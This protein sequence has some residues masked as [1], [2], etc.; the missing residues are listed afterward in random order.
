ML[1]DAS[2]EIPV[3]VSGKLR[4]RIV[5]PAGADAKT[6]EAAAMAEPKIAELIHGKTIAK[7]IVI[8][9]KL[10]NIVAK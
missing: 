9:G 3:Q 7:V 8:P 5:V 4:G 6:L 1:H 10:V 2:V